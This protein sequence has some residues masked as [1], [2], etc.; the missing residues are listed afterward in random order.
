[1]DIQEALK[2]VR[3]AGYSVREPKA[4]KQSRVGP[5]CVVQFADGEIF[6]MTTHSSDEVPD[7]ERGIRLANAAYPARKRAPQGREVGRACAA[8]KRLDKIDEK[9]PAKRRTGAS[10]KRF[11]RA[12]QIWRE[13]QV[14]AVLIWQNAVAEP[15]FPPK[16][17]SARFER[18]GQVIARQ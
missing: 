14:S 18:D 12:L 7:F 10:N 3:A 8:L 2:V 5:T 9:Y 16:V 6:R 13:R 15:H 17:V 4:K 1:M 11:S